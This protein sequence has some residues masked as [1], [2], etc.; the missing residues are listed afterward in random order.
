MSSSRK[1]D[2]D[3]ILF[4]Y[5]EQFPNLDLNRYIMFPKQRAL[6]IYFQNFGEKQLSKKGVKKK[7]INNNKTMI[8][9]GPIVI[10]DSD[11]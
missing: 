6:N 1:R 5:C 2:L 8:Q 9:G 10:G 3:L 4:M 7:L 11:S